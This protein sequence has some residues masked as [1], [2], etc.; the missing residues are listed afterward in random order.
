MGKLATK[1]LINGEATSYTYG[2]TPNDYLRWDFDM[3]QGCH[4]DPGYAG[5][6]CSK[7]LCPRGDDP[8]TRN[9]VNA[10]QF[11]KCTGTSGSFSLKFREAV[12]GTITPAMTATQVKASLEQMTTMGEVAVTFS[13]GATACET[14]GKNIIGVEF[15]TEHGGSSF[16][17]QY[18]RI[19]V[20]AVPSL[21]LST[22]TTV[23]LAFAY[24]TAGSISASVSSANDVTKTNMV[25]TKEMNQCSDRGTCDTASGTCMCYTGMD[26]SNGQG[27]SGSRGDCGHIAPFLF[28]AAATR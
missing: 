5:Y 25:G 20:A 10:V 22:S 11:F 15:L 23:S 27:L 18:L 19:Y 9:Q 6:D 12:S 4:C 17:D 26:S 21:K 3:V 2:V 24:S 13:Y 14:V 16:A 1:T 7:R 8:F 28:R